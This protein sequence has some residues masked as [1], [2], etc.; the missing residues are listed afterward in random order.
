MVDNNLVTM[1]LIVGLAMLPFA[2]LDAVPGDEIGLIVLL[3]IGALLLVNQ[4][5][6]QLSV[7]PMDVVA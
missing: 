1:G 4:S 2:F 3:A 5:G 7:G 6:G